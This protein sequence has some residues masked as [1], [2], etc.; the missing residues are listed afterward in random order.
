MQ[1]KR[2]ISLSKAVM[3]YRDPSRQTDLEAMPS[4]RMYSAPEITGSVRSWA[5]F[6]DSLRL[7]KTEA[8]FGVAGLLFSPLPILGLD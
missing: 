6:L 3:A 5:T 1:A 2:P 4:S 7:G 8:W